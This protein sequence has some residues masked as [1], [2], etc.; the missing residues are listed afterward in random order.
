MK[1]FCIFDSEKENTF[2]FVIFDFSIDE[3]KVIEEN[4][5]LVQK[6]DDSQI[7]KKKNREKKR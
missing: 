5:K 3:T 7:K 6:F 1:L 2:S 4:L